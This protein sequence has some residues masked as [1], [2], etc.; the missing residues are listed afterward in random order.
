M[1][2]TLV[3]ATPSVVQ[4][5]DAAMEST[6]VPATPSVVQSADA[7]MESTGQDLLATE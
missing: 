4:S 3:P 1:E 7:A 2:S 6:L 5:V